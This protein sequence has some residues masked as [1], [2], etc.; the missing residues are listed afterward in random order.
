M[1]KETTLAYIK[2]IALRLSDSNIYGGASAMI[3]AGFSKNAEAIGNKISPPDWGELASDMY[4][5]LYPKPSNE[6]NIKTWESNKLIK[7][8]GK[9]TL[10]LAEEYITFFDRNKMNL[11]IEK[12]VSDEM[13]I[14]SSLHKRLLSQN[15]TD[16]FTT[17]YDT[18]LER[19]REAVFPKKDY[20]VIYSK[21]NLPGSR[22]A[23]PRI[24]KLHG[25]IPNV[26]PYIIS[27]EDFR[28]YPQKFAAFVNTVQQALIETTLCMIGFSGND[29][30]FLNWHGWL[31][32]NLG[33]NC[34][35]IYLIGL[36]NDSAQIEKEIFK[37]RKIALVDLSEL[38]DGTEVNKFAA[39][40]DK[41]FDYIEESVKT[42][43]FRDIAP[44]YWEDEFAELPVEGDYIEK[45][46]EISD[47]ILEEKGELIIFP[48]EERTNYNYYFKTKLNHLIFKYKNIDKK[49]VHTISN[50]IK[51]QRLSLIPLYTSQAIKLLEICRKVEEQNITVSLEWVM[52]IYLYIMEM[53]RVDS[54]VKMYSEVLE[55]VE[56]LIDKISD[57]DRNLYRIELAKNAVGNFQEE[58]A[59]KQLSLIK[60]ENLKQKIMMAGLYIQLANMKK[61]ETLLKEVQN[62]LGKLR[63][64]A[65]FM[66]S[67]KSYLSLC[68]NAF[69]VWQMFLPEYAD[70]EYQDNSFKTRKIIVDLHD[71]LRDEILK[72]KAKDE[73]RDNVF[74]INYSNGEVGIIGQPKSQELSM[75]FILMLD[76][77]CLPL[78]TEQSLLLP[79]AVQNIKLTSENIMWKMSL[80]ARANNKDVIERVFSRQGI[81][82][83]S[84]DDIGVLY[85]NIWNHV[86]NQAYKL[87][88]NKIAFLDYIN[89]LNILSRIAVFLDD[90]K[91]ID[92]I[93]YISKIKFEIQDMYIG[94]IRAIIV[95][96]STRFNK[97]VTRELLNEI[98][99]EADSRLYLATYF[100]EVSIEIDNAEIYYQNAIALLGKSEPERDNGIAQIIFLWKNCKCELYES[101]IID[102]LWKGNI[103]E[104]PKSKIFLEV[105]WEDLPAAEYVDFSKLYKKVI[106]DGLTGEIPYMIF[107]YVNLFYLTS[108]ISHQNYTKVIFDGRELKEML[109]SIEKEL[110]K[111]A[112]IKETLLLLKMGEIEEQKIRHINE[113]STMIYVLNIDKE[114]ADINKI[115]EGIFNTLEKKGYSLIAVN[116]VKLALKNNY[117]EAL[118]VVKSA[119]WSN[120]DVM[121]SEAVL[122]LQLIEY[123]SQ[124]DKNRNLIKET[125]LEIIDKLQ[126]SDIKYVKSIWRLLERSI[127]EILANDIGQQDRIANIYESCIR[128]YSFKGSKG[129]KYYYEAMYNCNSSLKRYVDE[130]EKLN[131]EKRVDLKKVIDYVKSL[132]VPELS[133]I[134]E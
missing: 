78:F 99:I 134:W 86:C 64:N 12:N 75:E 89:A 51:I 129:N 8:S 77:L 18:L 9:N 123:L 56:K 76:L 4:I 96:L 46:L 127:V 10:H 113:L 117:L 79:D 13:F 1:S 93:K 126:Y 84:K 83:L 66:A 131:I 114:Q 68:R 23:L 11:L 49:L 32:D 53:Y 2:D 80:L 105:V 109:H 108:N 57:T 41:F 5:E 60:S 45:I 67:Y 62:E 16:I 61:A 31:L 63:M 73:I 81:A 110:K 6:E 92:L 94:E 72:G 103:D 118:G 133:A 59:N 119:F 26:R 124:E 112:G 98:F 128:S 39:A 20:K 36:F 65:A 44:F 116:S 54:D 28:S 38:L 3:G 70:S 106:Y 88:S 71:E 19:T 132:D 104:F 69:S 35:Q 22:G 102:K 90:S 27:E 7:T 24:I 42:A 47:K 21:D 34:P 58:E 122:G 15:W 101:E 87:F 121:I 40:Y 50:I 52:Q 48:K 120:D 37:E 82:T 30:N 107:R 91:I 17:N 55:K 95:R 25:S 74:E 130:V 111:E 14:P 97:R 29:P 33:E 85:E 100:S 125:V 43:S 115:L